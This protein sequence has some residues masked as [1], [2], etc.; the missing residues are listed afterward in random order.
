MNVLWITI[1]ILAI[2]I[3]ANVMLLWYCK[4]LITYVYN[5]DSDTR[6]VLESIVEYENHLSEVYN[7]DLFFGEPVLEALL[8]HTNDLVGDLDTY[9]D[10]NQSVLEES[11]E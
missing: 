1:P 6:V 5:M 3:I 9:L 4:K 11:N 7:R 2:S 8:K 10:T